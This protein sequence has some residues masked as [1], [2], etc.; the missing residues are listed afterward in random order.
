MTLDQ[1]KTFYIVANAGSFTS[2]AIDLNMDQ[3]NVSRK[4]ISMETRLRTKLFKR[5]A[6]GIIL[7]PEGQALLEETKEVLDRIEGMKNIVK[8]VHNEA[9]GLLT[10]GIID[11]FYDYFILPHLNKF[12]EKYPDINLILEKVDYSTSDL[13]SGGM[14]VAVRP[15]MQSANNNIVQEFVTRLHIK[16]YASKDYLE[17]F[18]TPERAEDLGNHR[19]IAYGPKNDL[20]S[21]INWHLFTGVSFG[22]S[23]EPYLQTSCVKT[24]LDLTEK[25]FGICALSAETASGN[26]NLIPVLPA[27][28]GSIL[29][30]F[31]LYPTLHKNAI[32]VKRF[33][34]FIHSIFR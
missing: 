16:L 30:F 19:L 26:Q 32:P 28:E 8:N 2:A 9:R 3:S 22:K 21:T 17:K 34:E 29:D 5:K 10:V 14:M 6:R 1:L 13:D 12:L 7:T 27:L 15:Y 24:R 25:G 18:G 20:F 4:I 31:Y 33:G 11:S 23:H